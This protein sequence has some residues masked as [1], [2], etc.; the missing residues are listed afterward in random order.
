MTVS[1]HV[2]TA[3]RGWNEGGLADTELW[4]GSKRTKSRMPKTVS[5]S[6]LISESE[7]EDGRRGHL[8]T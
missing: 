4:E 5:F 7:S 6:E 8:D 2:E 3:R 1:L